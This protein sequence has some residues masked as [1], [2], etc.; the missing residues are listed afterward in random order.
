LPNAQRLHF[1]NVFIDRSGD[2]HGT[3]AAG[4]VVKVVG[5]LRQHLNAR[6][7]DFGGL[8]GHALQR[9]G[10]STMMAPRRFTS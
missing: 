8:F 4:F 3:V 6:I 2:R 10:C 9:L 5:C 1:E 7:L